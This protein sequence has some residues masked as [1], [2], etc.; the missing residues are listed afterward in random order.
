MRF[1]LCVSVCVLSLGFAAYGEAPIEVGLDFFANP[2]HSPLYVADHLGFF[3]EEG[4]KLHL[5][6][7]GTASDPVK[8]A[9][10]RSLDVALTPQINYLIA[11]SAGLPLL[12]IGALIDHSLGGLLMRQ[13][14]GTAGIEDLRGKAIGYSLEP[15]EP[16]LWRTMLGCAGIGED[17]FRLINVGMSTMQALL[18]GNVDAIGAFRNFERIQAEQ[19]GADV[20]FFPQED[21]CIPPTY[22]IVLVSHPD[23]VEE[24]RSDLEG[25]L[26]ALA[27]G[28]EYTVEHPDDAIR[29]FLSIHP[30]LDD[31]LNRAAFEATVPLYARGARHDDQGVWETLSG[32]LA[33]QGL[34]EEQVPTG[35]LYTGSLL[36]DDE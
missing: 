34:L 27:R 21:Y 5:F 19:L 10:A 13:A 31:A 1:F 28:I 15:L 11:R 29:I 18:A 35:D 22:E 14:E 3:A 36:P 4:L 8:L 7:P 16:I 23:L 33:S 25:F 32:Y 2:N 6:I 12:S 9:A 20:A 24:R 30:D 26:R 17:E